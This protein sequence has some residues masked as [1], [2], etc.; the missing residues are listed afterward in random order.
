MNTDPPGTMLADRSVIRVAGEDVRGFLQGLVTADTALLTPDAP[1][2][3]ALL[4]P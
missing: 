3:A 2:W 1:A 4:S